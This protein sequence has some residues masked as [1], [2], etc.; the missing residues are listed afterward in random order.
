MAACSAALL[1][2]LQGLGPQPRSP[3]HSWGLAC[4]RCAARCSP[5]ATSLPPHDTHSDPPSQPPVKRMAL[6]CLPSGECSAVRGNPLPLGPLPRREDPLNTQHF[7]PSM[8]RGALCAATHV[9]AIPGYRC[10]FEPLSANDL[11][12]G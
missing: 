11:S 8:C 9:G 3:H 4:P 1:S 5:P 6:A 7:P 2:R 10:Y 12:K